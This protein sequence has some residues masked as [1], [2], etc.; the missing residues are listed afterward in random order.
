MAAQRLASHQ[1]MIAIDS[2]MM[3]KVAAESDMTGGG[4]R[5]R[6]ARWMRWGLYYLQ[7]CWAHTHKL[8]FRRAEVVP[9]Q[10]G[11]ATARLPPPLPLLRRRSPSS[12]A[13][14][15]P[16]P[17]HSGTRIS[18]SPAFINPPEE[19]THRESSGASSH[20]SSVFFCCWFN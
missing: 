11:D 8:C 20:A 13:A 10:R 15:P 4:C 14:P 18:L 2:A 6:D 5:K 3:T 1:D 16:P 12:A 7:Q 17:L 9:P 19:S